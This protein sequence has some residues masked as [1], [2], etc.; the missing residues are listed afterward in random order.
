MPK[1]KL[2]ALKKIAAKA[3]E[4]PL[5]SKKPRCQIPLMSKSKKI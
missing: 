2:A 5:A 4:N 3:P 1:S